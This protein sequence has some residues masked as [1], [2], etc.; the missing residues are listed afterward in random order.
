V[1]KAIFPSQLNNFFKSN[2]RHLPTIGYRTTKV[3][4]TIKVE[5]EISAILSSRSPARHHPAE[6]DS[7][8]ASGFVTFVVFSDLPGLSA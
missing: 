3:T 1:T 7:G 4:K 8:E 2:I 5:Q 6:T